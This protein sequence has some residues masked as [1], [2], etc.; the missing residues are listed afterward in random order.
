MSLNGESMAHW[1]HRLLGA[2]RGRGSRVE[3]LIEPQLVDGS[4]AAGWTGESRWLPRGRT[5]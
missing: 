2:G 1:R 4:D 5:A 3:G